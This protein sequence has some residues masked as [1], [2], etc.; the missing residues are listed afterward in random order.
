MSAAR[1]PLA[2]MMT[3]TRCKAVPGRGHR[4]PGW[5][6]AAGQAGQP[7]RV[8]G[9]GHLGDQPLRA[10]PGTIQPMPGRMT[11]AQISTAARLEATRLSGAWPG[12]AACRHCTGKAPASSLGRSCCA[13]W[14]AI[15]AASCHRA[16]PGASPARSR[17][18]VAPVLLASLAGDGNG[19][20]ASSPSMI[21]ARQQG[22][23][24]G[25]QVRARREAAQRRSACAPARLPGRD[26]AAPSVGPARLHHWPARTARPATRPGIPQRAGG[27]AGRCPARRGW[28]ASTPASRP[29]E[30]RSGTSRWST[31]ARGPG[32]TGRRSAAARI[33]GHPVRGGVPQVM[34][35][36]VRAEHRVGPL[37]HPV[38]C[39]IGQRPERLA[40]RPPQR[41][42]PARLVPARAS[43]PGTAAATRTRPREAGTCCSAR[44]PLRTTVISCWPG[45]ASPLAG[46][47][48]LRRP[49]PGRHPE[50]HQR[51]V[52]VRAQRREQLARTSHPGSAA[53]CAAPASAG[54]TRRARPERLHRV[55]GAR[56]RGCHGPGP[57]GTG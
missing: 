26:R 55:A 57:A 17:D 49:H 1:P 5:H 43:A 27:E 18:P 54:T 15:V 44:D 47:E 21:C 10:W 53:A 6:R 3:A 16:E 38:R 42:V 7:G 37:E 22:L 56:P 39:V 48:Q 19:A 23:R 28:N 35:R 45:S 33:T 25:V 24:P 46:A 11:S 20:A 9:A 40:Q 52:P 4:R 50:R 41:L 14:P 13:G 2:A 36:P 12:T 30:R 32:S 31:G 8:A 51:P 34:Q 29:P